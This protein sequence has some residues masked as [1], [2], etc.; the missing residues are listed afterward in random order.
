MGSF[1]LEGRIKY[2]LNE[3]EKKKR[4]ENEVEGGEEIQKQNPILDL[5]AI[6]SLW[7]ENN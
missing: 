5:S 6:I 3:N 4:I 1:E 7:L 2:Y